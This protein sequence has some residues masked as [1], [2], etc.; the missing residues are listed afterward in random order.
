MSS[1]AE[2][3]KAADAALNDF[4]RIAFKV[5]EYGSN[6]SR[7]LQDSFG[8]MSAQSWLRLVVIVGGY[9]LFRSQLTQYLSRKAVK[10]MEK[11]DVQDQA[12]A[13]AKVTANQLRS[14]K[15]DVVE[16]E[17]DEYYEGQGT[18]ADWGAKARTRQR[19]MLKKLM[20]KEEQRNQD[21]EDDE[22]IADLLQ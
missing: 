13:K 1:E 11:K 22:D 6:A 21:D 20:E 12:A 15:P 3:P 18:G 8:N 19:L 4:G 17:E 5:V 7:N 10:D 2:Q 16:E 9:I 14:G